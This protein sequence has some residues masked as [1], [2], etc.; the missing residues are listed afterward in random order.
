MKYKINNTSVCLDKY[1]N[2]VGSFLSKTAQI[3]CIRVEVFTV[4]LKCF[5]VSSVSMLM[6]STCYQR[7]DILNRCLSR[8]YLSSMIFVSAIFR[9]I[10]YCTR[11]ITPPNNEFHTQSY[12]QWHLLN[13]NVFTPFEQAIRRESLMNYESENLSLEMANTCFILHNQFASVVLKYRHLQI[14]IF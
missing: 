4:L 14:M 12:T 13:D 6:Q 2:L 7:L 9:L 8:R 11:E 1:T 3:L 5:S 10:T